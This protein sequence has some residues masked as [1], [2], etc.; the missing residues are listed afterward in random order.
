MLLDLL[1]QLAGHWVACG[2]LDS[3]VRC[4][5]Q[6]LGNLRALRECGHVHRGA[7]ICRALNSGSPPGQVS[8][9]L[10]SAAAPVPVLNDWGQFARCA[11]D[12]LTAV[13]A[14]RSA[15]AAAG[16]KAPQAE[17]AILAVLLC[18]ALIRRGELPEAA[19][20]ARRAK[21]HA[22]QEIRRHEGI[23]TAETMYAVDAAA[24]AAVEVATRASGPAGVD[25]ELRELVAVHERQRGVLRNFNKGTF[26]PPL[27]G[28]TGPVKPEELLD[29]RPAALAAALRG[30]TAEARRIL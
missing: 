1:E 19:H 26:L 29:G 3:A 12:A 22:L 17:H 11:G 10:A 24:A 25:A 21:Q 15:Y 5:W 13:A 8:A 4:Y 2:D 6:D 9:A 27:P 14:A 23:P 28:P 20:W 16:P 30:D 18:D 7:R